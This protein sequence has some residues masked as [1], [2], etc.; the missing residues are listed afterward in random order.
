MRMSTSPWTRYRPR[1]AAPWNLARA[2]SLGRRAGFAATWGEIERDLA[3]GPESAVDRVLAAHSRAAG[4][5]ADFASTADLLGEA[6]A[7]SGDADRLQ[8]WWLYR[9]LFTP[10]PLAE[11][12]T[13]LWHNHF[14]TSQ[15]KVD[16]VAAM[17]RQNETIRR[18]ARGPFGDFLRDFLRDPALLVWLDSP[19]NRKGKPNENLARELMELF[20]LGVGHYSEPDVKEAARALT[21]R[22]IAQGQYLFKKE[23]HDEGAKTILG[24]T[25]RFDGDKLADLLLDQ[26][27]TA[28]RLAWRLCRTFLGENVGDDAAILELA[29]RLRSDELHIGRGVET[30]LRSELFFSERNLHAQVS[31]PAGFVVG[32]V[33]SLERFNRPP[34]TLLL[35]EWTGRMGEA[36]FFPPNV[37][38]WPGG[39]SWLS[40]RA[41][42][43]RANFAAALV[44]GRLN[45]GS[46]ADVP[47]LRG[48]AAR[49][50]RGNTTDDA[51]RFFGALLLGRQL[52]PAASETVRRA[53]A[54]GGGSD[55]ERFNRTVALL[56]SRPEA[57][58]S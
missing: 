33:R 4:V 23:N 37:G 7:G 52:D 58:L 9:M 30:I 46:A 29:G 44:E 43:A 56:L 24:K 55:S 14:A 15:L 54:A 35:A 12:L 3:D 45:A 32:T 53:G 28:W 20:T 38:G 34:S 51:L 36:L 48:L 25:D 27:P 19:A 57:Q 17:K 10:D 16:D 18:R 31:D 22:T 49:H 5:P 50:G 47:D 41:V 2:W 39:R 6:A 11:R 8:A 42:V 13:L 26:P 40:G 1:P 21:G